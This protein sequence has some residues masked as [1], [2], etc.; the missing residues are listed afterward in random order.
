MPVDERPSNI[1]NWLQ[2]IEVVFSVLLLATIAV[3]VT[4]L[5]PSLGEWT[6]WV[7][8]FIPGLLSL[9]ALL[10]VGIDVFRVFITRSTSQSDAISRRILIGKVAIMGAIGLLAGI[11]LFLV[12]QTVL[13]A[14]IIETGGG[15][16]FGPFLFSFTGG[17][18]AVVVLARTAGQRFVS[19][20]IVGQTPEM[21]S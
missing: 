17:L 8:F 6:L 20:R 7:V 9:A 2:R 4:P 15:V 3:T 1:R 18:L 16:I 11:T 14:T 13:I 21:Q 12:V 10:G 5:E 19:D